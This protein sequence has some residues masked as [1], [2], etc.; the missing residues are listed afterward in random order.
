VYASQVYQQQM[1]PE[2]LNAIRAMMGGSVTGGSDNGLSLGSSSQTVLYHG[3][4]ASQTEGIKAIFVEGD[5][6]LCIYSGFSGGDSIQIEEGHTN[7]VTRQSLTPSS[8]PDTVSLTMGQD[9]TITMEPNGQSLDGGQMLLEDI[10]G[11][12]PVT[13]Q[14][15][16]DNI[17][18]FTVSGNEFTFTPLNPGTAA[19]TIEDTIT[20]NGEKTIS[21]VVTSTTAYSVTVQNDG[22]GTGSASPASAVQG[23]T[24]TLSSVPNSGYHFKEW[25]AV[26]PASLAITVDTFT[27]PDEDVTVMAVFEADA[28]TTYTVTFNSNGSVYSTKTVNAGESIGSANWP[29]DP[30]RNSYTF[31]GWFTG[32]HGADSQFTSATPVNATTTVYAKWTYSGGGGG[33]GGGSTP[34]SP[35]YKADVKAGNGAETTFPVTVDKNSGTASIDIGSQ[36]L[37]SSGTVITIPLVPDVDTY[38]VGIPV[39][40]LS[41]A[42]GQGTLTLNTDAGSVAVPSNM[43]TGVAGI[44]GSKAQITIGQGDKSNL[45]QD[46]RDA[47]GDKPLIQLTL[48]IDG[49]QTNWNNPDAPVTV[50]IP[51]TPTAEELAH[52]ESIVVWYIDGSGN[53]VTIPNGCYDQTTGM[54]TFVTNHFSDYAVAYNPVSFND[55]AAGAWYHGAVSFIAARGIT[56]GTG[57]GKYS[58]NAKL[59][60]GELLVMI[61]K[62]YG[63]VPDTNPVDNFADAGNTYYTGYLA[64]A[65]RLG[66]SGGVGNNMFAPGKEITR[67]EMFTLLYN[68]IKAIGQLPTGT[69]GKALSDFTDASNVADWA[70]EAMTLLVKTGTIGGSNGALAPLST[71]TRAEMAQVLYNLLG[72]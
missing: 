47:I 34:S 2:L 63:I 40:G 38:S 7:Y 42:D 29:P 57:N 56:D 16:S 44:S 72:K 61:M 23:A 68:A 69:S 32:E 59:T 4:A 66:I 55:V 62:A 21:I 3:E 43:L 14:S 28:A 64:T 33:G 8:L 27:M 17:A 12:G 53:V 67:Q 5:P 54:V 65:K 35:T 10:L 50:S 31:G 25:K 20:Y 37:T 39:P 24:V 46:V 70:E 41:T 13:L 52:P 19:L 58:P 48:S 1:Y 51:Y 30:T 18:S 26:S 71:T 45:P 6:E 11:E 36:N 60:R 49:R 15:G 9:R 22:H